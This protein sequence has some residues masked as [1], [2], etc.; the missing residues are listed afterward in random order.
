MNSAWLLPRRTGLTC[1]HGN[2][3]VS[4]TNWP[5]ARI[6]KVDLSSWLTMTYPLSRSS[7]SSTGT[8]H[9]K[10]S[11]QATKRLTNRSRKCW[12]NCHPTSKTR[13][14]VKRQWLSLKR[15]KHSRSSWA[16]A[17]RPWI[18]N[19]SRLPSNSQSQSYATSTTYTWTPPFK[20]QANSQ[21]NW[22]KP[23]G[24]SYS[25]KNSSTL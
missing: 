14:A 8:T 23:T 5:R 17:L 22:R 4:L 16:T 9:S 2:C 15:Y 12:G 19:C 10:S 21:K 6:M 20:R 24:V 11:I 7:S 13:A 18:R 25:T 1:Y 3:L